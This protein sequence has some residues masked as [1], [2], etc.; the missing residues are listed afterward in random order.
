MR[1]E[2]GAAVK[3]HLQSVVH[4]YNL[5]DDVGDLSNRP[6]RLPPSGEPGWNHKRQHSEAAPATT[7]RVFLVR[8]PKSIRP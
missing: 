2:G 3:A 6:S 7:E 8:F 1:A 5:P 4:K